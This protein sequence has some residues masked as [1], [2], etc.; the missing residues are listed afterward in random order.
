MNT[1]PQQHSPESTST[2]RAECSVCHQEYDR[3]A[4]ESFESFALIPAVCPACCD[5]EKIKMQREE[6]EKRAHYIDEAIVTSF[7]KKYIGAT[8]NNFRT[9]NPSQERALDACEEFSVS[10]E[11]DHWVYLWGGPGTG[12]TH[13]CAATMRAILVPNNAIRVRGLNVL[14]M[15]LNMRSKVFKGSEI[16]EEEYVERAS[17]GVLILDDLGAEKITD[18]VRQAIYAIINRRERNG[19]PTMITSNLSLDDLAKN[20]GDDR[21]TSRIA[22]CSKV[23]RLNVPDQRIRDMAVNAGRR[24]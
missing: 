8:F 9:E 24:K 7:G 4:I 5:L 11:G 10:G 16:T 22:G 19:I 15:I 3:K 6:D 21:I 20:L 12:K 13:L 18:W 17:S 1:Q 2:F 14:D 23:L